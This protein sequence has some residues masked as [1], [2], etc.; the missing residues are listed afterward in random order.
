MTR[1]EPRRPKPATPDTTARHRPSTRLLN[2]LRAA[3]RIG[4]VLLPLVL[5]ALGQDAVAWGPVGHRT[6]GEIAD[7]LLD[8]AARAAVAELL[9]DDRDRDERRSGRHSL[10]D[11]A[12]WADEIRGTPADHPHWHYDNRPVCHSEAAGGREAAG[13]CARGECATAQLAVQL[14]I[15][16]D[17]RR[18]RRERNEALK[19]VVHLVGDL[20][21]PLHAADLAEGGN[22]IHVLNDRHGGGAAHDG[23]H[24]GGNSLHAYWD[25]RLVSLAL[26]PENGHL[27]HRTQLRLAREAQDLSAEQIDAPAEQ[28]AEESSELARTFALNLSSISCDASLHRRAFPMVNL[29]HD[30]LNRGKEV[31]EHRLV[32]AGVRLAH[33][34]NARLAPGAQV[35]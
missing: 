20:H 15:L 10:A 27:P 32:L 5:G 4:L 22:L 23:A 8:P 3:R 7:T 26:H 34:L 2:R 29:S 31:V 17:A 28:W 6:V 14:D 13:W 24:S 19:W 1:S 35:R 25:S 33:V 12:D 21:Q 9:T 30:Y 16:A 11:I 18:P